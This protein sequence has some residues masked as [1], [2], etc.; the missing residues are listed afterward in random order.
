MTTLNVLEERV[1]TMI[2]QNDNDHAEILKKTEEITDKLDRNFVP[3][4]RFAPVEKI[5]YGMVT[6]ILVGVVG[7]IIKLVIL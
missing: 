3:L 2:K 1:G 6:I 5:V 4:N 7:A